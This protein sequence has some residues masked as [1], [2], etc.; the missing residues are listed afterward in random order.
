[1]RVRPSV[2]L[3]FALT[4]FACGSD[5]G[6]PAGWEEA[7]DADAV[8]WLLNVGG[9]GPEALLAVGGAPDGG[10]VWRWNG[11]VWS[12]DVDVPAVPLLNWTQ[13]FATEE[14]IVGNEGT[15]LRHDATG[16]R[17]SEAPTEE[18]LWGV[19]GDSPSDLWAVGGS[20]FMGS[21]A[22][23]LRYDGSAWR[24]ITTPELTRAGVRAFFKVWGRAADD[25][26]IVGQA[27]VVLHWDG[28]AFEEL[29]V[30]ASDDLIAVWGLADGRV[31]VVGGRGN[32]RCFLSDGYVPGGTEWREVSLGPAPGLNGVWF[33]DDEVHVVGVEGYTATIDFHGG[34]FVEEYLDTRLDLHAIF[35]TSEG[36]TT[37]GGNFAQAAGPYR[38]V[39]WR[40]AW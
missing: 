12:E 5:P 38:G 40:R 19:W 9:T 33:R 31:A 7:F 15:V 13:A 18:N 36:L 25:V 34:D 30:G 20:G 4:L 16:Y 35:G 24:Q 22:T 11:S 3:S 37:V 23:I 1:M 17:L 6:E 27:G 8:G 29:F 10:V 2:L 21:E 32:A 28:S 39:A 26:W 14:W